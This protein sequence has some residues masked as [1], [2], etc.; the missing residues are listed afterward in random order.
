MSSITM[1]TFASLP[2]VIQKVWKL[3]ATQRRTYWL[4]PLKP[5]SR[6]AG[7]YW[8]VIENG[9]YYDFAYDK[10][11][12]TEDLVKIEEMM[13]KNWPQR[14]NLF[15]VE[16]F[17]GPRHIQYFKSIGEVYKVKIIEDIQNRKPSPFI[18]K[19]TLPTYAVFHTCHQPA[20]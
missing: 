13:Q 9:F 4:M 3:S 15:H 17:R 16:Q 1:P 10:G 19:A 11:F 12:T 2:T 20:C 6:S 8:P 5:L 7:H 14:T 18:N